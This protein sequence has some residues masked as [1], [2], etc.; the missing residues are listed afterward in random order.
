MK[1]IKQDQGPLGIL[2]EDKAR[3]NVMFLAKHALSGGVPHAEDGTH[4]IYHHE[5]LTTCLLYTSSEPTR[6]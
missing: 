1:H 3:L 5:M 2:D 4:A 6:P